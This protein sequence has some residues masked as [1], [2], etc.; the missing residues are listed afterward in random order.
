MG[1]CR[2]I[3][4]ITLNI[5]WSNYFGRKYLGSITRVAMMIM[6][7]GSACG[8]LSLGIDVDKFHSYYKCNYDEETK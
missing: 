2:G 1:N 5:V 7:I 3:E 6:D 4:R 8:P